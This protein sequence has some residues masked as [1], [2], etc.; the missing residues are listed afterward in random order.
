MKKLDYVWSTGKISKRKSLLITALES[1][2]F[3]EEIAKLMV[4]LFPEFS[5]NCRILINP[6]KTTPIA[7]RF[8]QFG[9][10]C[11]MFDYIYRFVLVLAD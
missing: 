2:I 10:C 7:P 8:F 5:G 1:M 6:S 9:S 4:S 11:S 3:K